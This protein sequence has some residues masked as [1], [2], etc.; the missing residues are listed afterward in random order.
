MADEETSEF[1]Y[2]NFAQTPKQYKRSHEVALKTTVEL[3]L[4]LMKR[5]LDR[6]IGPKNPHRRAM[7]FHLAV[8]LLRMILGLEVGCQVKKYRPGVIELNWRKHLC[9]GAKCNFSWANPPNDEE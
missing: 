3:P 5:E 7:R 6:I 4:V 1:Y 8:E 9:T 2:R